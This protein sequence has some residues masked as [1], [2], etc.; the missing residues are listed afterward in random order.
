MSAH[1][2]GP[3]E[4]DERFITRGNTSLAEVF[5][6]SLDIKAQGEGDANARL[7]AAAPD[8]L[9]ALKDAKHVLRLADR[10][11]AWEQERDRVVG[12]IEDA[13]EKAGGA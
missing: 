9:D 1:T 5:D 2:P 11:A 7:I 10:S 6:V 8:L 12:C 3:W 4:T 13:I